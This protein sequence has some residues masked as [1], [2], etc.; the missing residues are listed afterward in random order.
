MRK[1]VKLYALVGITASQIMPSHVE[2]IPN[3]VLP[4]FRLF[5]VKNH[6]STNAQIRAA[7]GTSLSG[8]AYDTTCAR[9]PEKSPSSASTAAGALQ[10]RGIRLI[11]SG[12]INSS[13][14]ILANNFTYRPY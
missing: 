5:K 12:D 7:T 1:V 13:G 3:L 2:Y 10:P 8:L 14:K 11:T 4:T 9:T 6:N